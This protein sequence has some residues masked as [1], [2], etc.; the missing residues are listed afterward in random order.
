MMYGIGGY[1]NSYLYSVYLNEFDDNI[2]LSGQNAENYT[3][4]DAEAQG[5]V[6]RLSSTGYIEWMTYVGFMALSSE[7]TVSVIGN[8]TDN[9]YA[10]QVSGSGTYKF[11]ILKLTYAEGKLIWSK[12]IN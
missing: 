5:F 4:S 8:S 11:A 2:L 6:M 3:T 10:L 9:V 12:T 1:R 7:N